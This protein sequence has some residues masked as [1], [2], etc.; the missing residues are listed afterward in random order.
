MKKQTYK[1]PEVSIIN[2]QANSIIC[3]SNQKVNKVTATGVFNE[4][5]SA[6]SGGARS[7]GIGRCVLTR[8]CS[9]KHR[10][11]YHQCKSNL[12]VF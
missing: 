2:I 12:F 9:E 3:D 5:I 1:M 7:R 8:T 11:E 10:E 4:E 6:G